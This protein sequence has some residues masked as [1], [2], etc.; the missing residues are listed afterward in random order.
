MG[1]PAERADDRHAIGVAVQRALR[2]E[3]PS[4]IE[5]RIR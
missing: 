5:I 3:G 1:V 2:R 4:L